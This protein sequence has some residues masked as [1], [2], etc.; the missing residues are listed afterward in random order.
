MTTRGESFVSAVRRRARPLL[1]L[2]VLALCAMTAIIFV[3]RRSRGD[4]VATLRG[5]AGQVARDHRT[6]VGIWEGANVG[7]TF[8]VGDAVRTRA[9]STALLE[10]STSHRLTLEP[11]TQVRF[12]TRPSDPKRARVALEMGEM[13]LNAENDGLDLETDLGTVRVAAHGRARLSKAGDAMRLQVTIGAAEI[14]RNGQHLELQVGDAVEITPTGNLDRVAAG[15]TSVNASPSA[16]AGSGVATPNSPPALPKGG[17]FERGLERVDLSIAAGESIIIHDPRPPTAIGVLAGERCGS[18]ALLSIDGSRARPEERVGGARIGVALPSGTHR[19]T[20]Y[21]LS[22]G[23]TRGDKLGQGT[24]S[25]IPD[26]GL[27]RL[28]TSAPLTNVDADGRRYTVL[29]QSLQPRI[30]IQ[31]PNAPAAS[32]YVLTVNSPHGTKTLTASSPRYSFPSGSL[33]EGQHTLSFQ[34]AG[35]RS[36]DTT[37]VIRFD[38]AAPAASIASPADGSFAPGSSVLV[39]GTAQPGSVVTVGGETLQQDAQNRFSMPI[40]APADQALAIRF[41]Q[42]QRGVHY[43]LRRSAL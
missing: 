8:V 42:P 43:Y 39:S 38:N 26:A 14:D 16:P 1:V 21:C 7:A 31:W 6:S 3:M 25:I 35:R 23:G 15:S 19:Y 22:E 5:V 12:L 17:G 13:T 33:I 30:A 28:A 36:R 29:Y 40:S 24:I 9:H 34:A 4:V 11:D 27:R 41:V 32:S 37:V 10:L 2:L 20:V 18:G